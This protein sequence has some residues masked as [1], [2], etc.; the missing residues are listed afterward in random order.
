MNTLQI[1]LCEA[2]VKVGVRV[3]LLFHRGTA[4]EAAEKYRTYLEK[5]DSKKKRKAKVVASI[6]LLCFICS[7]TGCVAYKRAFV[8]THDAIDAAIGEKTDKQ[9][10]DK[11]GESVK[12]L[13]K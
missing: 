9:I 4:H 3:L 8:A 12:G 6:V 10:A 1:M 11:A 2:S 13:A 7:C 5:L